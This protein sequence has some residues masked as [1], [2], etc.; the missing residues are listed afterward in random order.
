MPV[1]R[2]WLLAALTVCLFSVCVAAGSARATD[3]VIEIN[4]A[5]A[6][7]GGVTTGDAPGFPVEIF[8]RGNFRLTSDLIVPGDATAGIA[9]YASGTQIDLNGFAIASTTVCSGVNLSCAP[10]G[11]G[12]GIDASAADSV[13]VR[14]GRVTGFGVYGVF[15]S[16][17]SRAKELSVDNN[18]LGGI[19]TDAAAV[20]SDNI[21][22]LNGGYGISAGPDSRVVEN[23]VVGNGGPGILTNAS[24]IYDRNVV[25]HNVGPGPSFAHARR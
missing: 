2:P 10:S 5:R 18:A 14:N 6:A 17:G 4:A 16:T 7:A 21:V 3:G 25:N 22:R 23:T 11:T 1:A 20:V 15:L 24:A 9:V 13:V 8:T 12:V 19:T